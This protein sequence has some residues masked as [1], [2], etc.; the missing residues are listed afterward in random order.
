VS[1]AGLAGEVFAASL[2]FVD[3]EAE[4]RQGTDGLAHHTPMIAFFLGIGGGDAGDPHARALPD[5]R[6]GRAVDGVAGRHSR[7]RHVTW[8]LPR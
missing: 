3:P 5:A 4:R 7:R 2:S 8:A 6:D 1:G